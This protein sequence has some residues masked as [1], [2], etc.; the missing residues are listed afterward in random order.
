MLAERIKELKKCIQRGLVTRV[1]EDLIDVDNPMEDLEILA[2]A[3]RGMD[4]LSNCF[5]QLYPSI[6][7]LLN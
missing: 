1:V 3:E 4:L 2:D 5:I 6:I 7:I